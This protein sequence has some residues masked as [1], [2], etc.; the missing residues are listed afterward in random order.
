MMLLLSLKGMENINTKINN[1]EVENVFMILYH[2][3]IRCKVQITDNFDYTDYFDNELNKIN[4][5]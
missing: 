1:S 2:S 4:K 3:E 5:S